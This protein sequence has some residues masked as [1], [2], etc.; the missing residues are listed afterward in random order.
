[1]P[2]A[3][4][5]VSYAPS[6]PL[7]P[8]AAACRCCVP[9]EALPREAHSHCW[10][11]S[12]I[13]RESHAV[14]P[15]TPTLARRTPHRSVLSLG[16]AGRRVF[17]QHAGVRC[18]PAA[19]PLSRWWNRRAQEFIRA[20]LNLHVPRALMSLACPNTQ[21]VLRREGH[22][23][24]HGLPSAFVSV[25]VVLAGAGGGSCGAG[26]RRAR[27]RSPGRALPRP[28]S[29]RVVGIRLQPV[30]CSMG[31]S[32]RATSIRLSKHTMAV[33]SGGAVHACPNSCCGGTDASPR[34]R[35]P[36]AGSYH[37]GLHSSCLGEWRPC[38]QVRR[39]CAVRGHVNSSRR[40]A[41]A[42]LLVLA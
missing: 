21:A 15:Q 31:V 33:S 40:G 35:S 6:Y 30:H 12:A 19:K 39:G 36:R 32:G 5:R 16:S 8:T 10:R 7:A 26:V 38:G 29:G 22:M 4:A 28:G 17:T 41:R 27:L 14:R 42:R 2:P 37:A 1:M 11:A 34:T 13:P 25:E 20:S 18:R 3:A 24:R 9:Q 23:R